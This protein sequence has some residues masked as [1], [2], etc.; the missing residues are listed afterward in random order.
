MQLDTSYIDH[1][2]L[3]EAESDLHSYNTEVYTIAI[4]S[5]GL[6]FTWE[7][8]VI[9]YLVRHVMHPELYPETMAIPF[10]EIV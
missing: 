8:T 2:E 5:T 9:Y 4:F 7:C 1:I 6:F 10:A 3:P